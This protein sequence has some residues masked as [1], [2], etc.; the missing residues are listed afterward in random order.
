[1][2]RKRVPQPPVHPLLRN[3]EQHDFWPAAVIA[4]IA[5][6]LLFS[7]ARQMT[8]VE[9]TDG[10][11]ASEVQLVK[12]FSRGGLQFRTPSA[13]NDPALIVDPDAATTAMDEAA[14]VAELPLRERY[15]VNTGA[16]DPC[17]T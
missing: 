11:S 10:A 13:A 14:R 9:T 16:V 2:R 8:S 4:A 3:T 5:L 6:A 12:A 7:G 1:M 15:R 17:P